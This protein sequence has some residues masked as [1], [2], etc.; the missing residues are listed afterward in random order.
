MKERYNNL[1]DNE[2]NTVF[3]KWTEGERNDIKVGLRV[4]YDMG[5]KRKV[6]EGGMIH[7]QV[8]AFYL[9]WRLKQ[10]LQ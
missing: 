6:L 10:L 3:G 7:Y 2:I 9:D 1:S 5:G 4:S 8:I